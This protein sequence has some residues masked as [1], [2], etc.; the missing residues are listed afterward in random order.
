MAR[1]IDDVLGSLPILP[2]PTLPAPKYI[3]AE[4]DQ[5]DKVGFCVPSMAQ[6]MTDEGW[7]LF[8]GLGHTGYVLAGNKAPVDC[9][10]I[11]KVV[12]KFHPST[13]LLQD[14]REWDGQTAGPGFDEED[15]LHNAWT[16][17]R[18]DDIFKLTVLKDAQNN[19]PYHAESAAEIGAHAWVVYYHPRIVARVAPYVRQGHLVRTY[20]TIDRTL[21]PPYTAAREGALL[22][23]AVSRAYPL[24]QRLFYRYT[25]LP[26]VSVKRHPGYG[27]NGCRTPGFMQEL[28]Q[29]KVAICTS[30]LY[31][32]A[33]RKIME[34]TACGCMVITDLPS[35]E[36]LPEI[37]GNLI[38]IG[39]D[40]P[41]RALAR[42]IQDAYEAYDPARQEHFAKLAQDR[43]D[44]RAEG[45]RLAHAI[46]DLRRSYVRA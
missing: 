24:R 27:R 26:G 1:K 36:V 28:T 7:Q 10:D 30:S 14:K 4:V 12:G 6:H 21:V 42:I 35:D 13:V 22:S 43:Y 2:I 41:I 15:R 31:G 3:G 39:P 37:D 33:L 17:Q 20:H 44:F 19:P 45:V 11:H 32:Y 9:T 8:Q 16:L 23:G 46:E 29:Y 18:R 40:I 34:A 5:R 25:Q 38:R